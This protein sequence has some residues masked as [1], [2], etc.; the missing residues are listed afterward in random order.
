MD[1]LHSLALSKRLSKAPFSIALGL[2][3]PLDGH[4][5]GTQMMFQF[6]INGAFR[7]RKNNLLNLLRPRNFVDFSDVLECWWLV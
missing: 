3:T 2:F 4:I 1:Q 7:C 5:E 6:Q